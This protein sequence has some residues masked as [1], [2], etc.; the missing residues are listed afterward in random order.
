MSNFNPL[1][2]QEA[3]LDGW[4][5]AGSEPKRYDSPNYSKH[6]ERDAFTAGWNARAKHIALGYQ[7]DVPLPAANSN[8]DTANSH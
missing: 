2:E 1:P 7:N 4:E 8:R 5:A 3:W 6:A